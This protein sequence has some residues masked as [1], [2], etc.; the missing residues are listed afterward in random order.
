MSDPRFRIGELARRTGVS[1]ALLRAWE[2]R[3]GLIEPV[4]SPGGFRLY[5]EDDEARIRLMRRYQAEGLSAAEAARLAREGSLVEETPTAGL[6]GAADE[7]RVALERFDEGEAHAVFDRALASLTL[8]SLLAGV[9]LRCLRQIGDRW[10]RGQVS[11]AQ[12]HFAA[13]VIRGRL[14]GLARDWGRGRGRLA[15]LAC[16]P[17]ELHDLALISF[18]LALRARGWRITFLGPDTPVN[19]L[20]EAAENL[21]PDLVVVS[22]TTARPFRKGADGLRR[23]GERVPLAVAGQGASERIA[24]ELDA[25][26]LGDDPVAEAERVST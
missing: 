14:L 25:R 23:I 1:T 16:A 6:D 17:G 19:T 24:E 21:A 10:E 3:Y 4:R 2:M 18:G 7:L 22:S 13:N 11:V 12:E 8:D 15:L 9:V 5:S 20:A 26:F